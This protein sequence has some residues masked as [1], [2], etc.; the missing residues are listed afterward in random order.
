MSF[1]SFKGPIH[2]YLPKPSI[3]YNE[4]QIPLL[5][6][7]INCKSARSALQMLHLKDEYTS[8]FLNFVIIG[9]CNS[10]ANCFYQQIYKPLMQIHLDIHHILNF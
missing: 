5:Y 10:T 2:A 1:F 3:K 9:L 8:C 4:K 7:H 6:I